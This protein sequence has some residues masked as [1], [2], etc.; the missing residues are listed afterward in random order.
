MKTLPRGYTLLELIVAVGIFSVVMLAATGAY[1]T[2]IDLDR[3][4]RAVNDVVSNLS[5]A[6]DSMSRTVRTGTAYKCNNS[7]GTPTCTVTPGTS[8]GFT[9]SETPTRSIVYSLS[10]GQVYQSVNGTTYP[11]TDPAITV[12]TLN[13]FVRG[14]GI[15]T[16]TKI[17]PQVTFIIAGSMNAG[18]G[19]TVSFSIEG[20]GTQRLLEIP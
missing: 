6:V 19:K 8:F 16:G 5:F 14:V 3:R 7:S 1:F 4:A 11:I 12:Q 17:Q 9:D 20:G 13:F 2:L 15:E 18:Q 10:N